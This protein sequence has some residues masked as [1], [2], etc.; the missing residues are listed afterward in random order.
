MHVFQSMTSVTI[1][2]LCKTNPAEIF[3]DNG[4]YCLCCWQEIT[5]P[6]V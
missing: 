4:D 6:N 3:Q 2:N 5:C 1:R